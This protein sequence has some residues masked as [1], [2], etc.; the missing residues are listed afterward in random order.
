MDCANWRAEP[1]L[2]FIPI[3]NTLKL[4]SSTTSK[5]FL[6]P[7]FGGGKQDQIRY[8]KPKRKTGRI[9]THTEQ[10]DVEYLEAQNKKSKARKFMPDGVYLQGVTQG[11]S[12]PIHFLFQK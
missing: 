11:F 12:P 7:I 10:A 3:P 1:S 9:L 4:A 8:A 5:K 6:S 2:G